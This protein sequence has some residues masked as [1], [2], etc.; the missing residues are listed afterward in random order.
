M[1]DL[2]RIEARIAG[3]IPRGLHGYLH[4]GAQAWRPADTA[5]V[6]GMTPRPGDDV[7]AMLRRAIEGERARCAAGHWTR[8]LPRLLRLKV[9]YV[10]E[11]HHR[12]RRRRD[13]AEQQRRAAA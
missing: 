3:I 9:A 6:L 10:A 8:A 13:A 5:Q 1:G 7:V 2:S 4:H 11:R 12:L